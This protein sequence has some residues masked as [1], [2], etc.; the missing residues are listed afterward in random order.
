M[1]DSEGQQEDP[2]DEPKWNSKEPSGSFDCQILEKSYFDVFISAMSTVLLIL[3]PPVVF[4]GVILLSLG[5]ILTSYHILLTGLSVIIFGAM[6]GLVTAFFFL[7]LRGKQ[8]SLS[9]RRRQKVSS[10]QY[11]RVQEENL[12]EWIC[13]DEDVTRFEVTDMASTVVT[14]VNIDRENEGHV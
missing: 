3:S 4:V 11:K 9:D 14:L 13:P 2:S 10:S 8:D 7:R 1:S 6:C 5:A 12:N